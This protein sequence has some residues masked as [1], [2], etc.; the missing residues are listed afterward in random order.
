MIINV[1]NIIKIYK[2]TRE[3]FVVIEEV[4]VWQIAKRTLRQEPRQLGRMP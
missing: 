4:E 3:H 1:R 2:L